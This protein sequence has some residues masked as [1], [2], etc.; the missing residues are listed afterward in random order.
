[1]RRVVDVTVAVVAGILL[2]PIYAVAAL[3]VR[4]RLG[5]PVLFRQVRSGRGGQEFSIVK[6][7]TMK[8]ERWAG[9]PDAERDTALGRRL[10]ALSVDEL[11][12]LWNVLR[13]DM[14]LIGP[15]PTLPEQVRHYSTRQRGRLAIRPGLTGWA[16]VNGRNSISWPERIELDLYYIEHRNVALDVRI[17]WRTVLHVLRQSGIYGEGGVNQ[18]FPAPEDSAA[19]DTDAA[20]AEP[21][22]DR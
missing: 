15:R 1:M 5:R 6:F 4:L 9:E 10:R 12:E 14:S 20:S 11:P 3:L 19:S 17:L 2:S 8:P 18:G 21:G 7:R 22:G 16:Q 13:G